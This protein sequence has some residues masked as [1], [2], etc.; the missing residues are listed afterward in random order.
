MKQIA[1]NF[2]FFIVNLF[3]SI[4]HDPS[5]FV[6]VFMGLGWCVVLNAAATLGLDSKIFITFFIVLFFI[7]FSNNIPF[8]A[9]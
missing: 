5:G 4:N 2:H 1:I 8:I 6:V 9:F 3:L 7:F